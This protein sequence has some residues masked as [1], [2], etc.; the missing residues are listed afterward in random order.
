MN[1][2][3][4]E[5]SV[6]QAIA[7]LKV[8]EAAEPAQQPDVY[9]VEPQHSILTFKF[10]ECPCELCFI[11]ESMD[12]HGFGTAMQSELLVCTNSLPHAVH[13][14]QSP[15]QLRLCMATLC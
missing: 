15:V 8:T 5:E 1:P 3:P 10:T 2:G 4:P 9:D 12:A 7:D 6:S 11:F 13:L 14:A